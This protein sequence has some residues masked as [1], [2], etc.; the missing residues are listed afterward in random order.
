MHRSPLALVCVLLAGLGP[1][2]ANGG[3]DGATTDATTGGDAAA[4]VARDAPIDTPSETP[5]VGCGAPG[6]P[7]CIGASC[8]DGLSCLADRCVPSC[9]VSGQTCCAGNKCD[10]TTVC[11]GGICKAPTD[12]GDEGKPCC[13]SSLCVGALVCT[14]GTCAKATTCGTAGAACC[15]GSACA[16]GLE[17][18]GGTCNACGAATQPC[19]TGGSCAAGASCDPASSKCVACGGVGQSCCA[20]SACAGGGYCYSGSCLANPTLTS[21]F[22]EGGECADLGIAHASGLGRHVVKGR[23][24]A[25]VTQFYRHSSC[26]DGFTSRPWGTTDATGTFIDDGGNPAITDCKFSQGGRWETYFTIDGAATPHV[27]GTFYNST[28]PAPLATCAGAMT[29]CP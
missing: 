17:C 14:G 9:G 13:A 24:S 22:S 26:G 28:C 15:A 25:P 6:A 11:V 20:G 18:S 12:C 5:V 19:C 4:D 23:P 7:C 27:F 29:F 2:C 8:L 16:A 1:A 10:A 21:T 3:G